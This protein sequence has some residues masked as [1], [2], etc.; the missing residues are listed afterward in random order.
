[1]PGGFFWEELVGASSLRAPSDIGRAAKP[2]AQQLADRPVGARVYALLLRCISRPARGKIRR[3]EKRAGRPRRA[4]SNLCKH[5]IFG[6]TLGA[7]AEMSDWSPRSHCAAAAAPYEGEA[8][9]IERKYDPRAT[10]GV[11]ALGTTDHRPRPLK[12]GETPGGKLKMMKAFPPGAISHPAARRETLVM[13]RRRKDGSQ[14]N[15]FHINM[16]GVP[17]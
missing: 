12:K 16:Y 8:N 6:F 15:K 13:L 4:V 7:A 11:L 17:G 9:R 1:M 3:A 5:V 14:R 2:G 10:Q